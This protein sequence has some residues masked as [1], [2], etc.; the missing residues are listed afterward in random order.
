[1]NTPL[2]VL[3]LALAFACS[4]L[5][6]AQGGPPPLQVKVLLASDPHLGAEARARHDALLQSL[7]SAG[8]TA[9]WFEFLPVD[10]KP[11]GF[12]HCTISAQEPRSCA[13]RLLSEKGAAGATIIVLAGGEGD[14]ASWLCVG[15]GARPFNRERQAIRFDLNAA[16]DAS[17]PRRGAIRA[18]AAGCITGAGAE[19]GW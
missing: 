7:G 17:S 14:R 8:P 6:L 1:M 4:P 5:A 12:E 10:I 13:S 18:Q 3:G 15:T 16:A 11:D 9:G 19:S 2:A